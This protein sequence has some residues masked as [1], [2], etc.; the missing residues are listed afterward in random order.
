MNETRAPLPAEEVLGFHKTLSNWG[1]FGPRDQLGTLNL[2][3]AA[4]RKA[5]AQSVRSG[6]TVSCA[7]PLPTQPSVENPNPVQHHMIGTCTEGWGGDYFAMAPHGFATSHIDALCH[8]FHE[9]KL[10]NG[11]PIEKVSAHGALELGIH[12]L[13]DGV[14]SRGVLLDVPASRGVLFLEAGE[15]IFADDLERAEAH[16]GVRV[17]SGDIL[18]VRT[19]RWA[20]REAKGPW[21]PR[22]SAAGLDA[23]CLPWLH[24]RGVAVLGC[25]G[26]SDVVPSRVEGVGLPIHSVA[27]VAMGLHLIDNL[28][29]EG[30]SKACAEE[31]R[32]DFLLTLAPLVLFRGTASPLNPIALF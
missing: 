18:L 22:L 13:K 6:R 12:E 8:I 4:K 29:L 5:A 9:G 15:P 3:T 21:D 31:K 28:D 23:S 19:G 25:D 14:V 2:I 1:R 10:Y 32:G 11:Y 27:I 24:A 16:G 26:V 20:L 17:E 7:R 30:L